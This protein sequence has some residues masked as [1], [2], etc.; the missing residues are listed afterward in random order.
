MYQPFV[1]QL[2]IILCITALTA[3]GGANTRHKVHYTLVEAQKPQPKKILLLPLD[4]KVKELSAGGV[5]EEVEEWTITAKS[6]MQA[7]LASYDTKNEDIEFVRLPELSPDE[8]EILDEHIALYH[9]VV[10]G[11]YN[12]TRFPFEA[13]KHKREKFDYTVGEGLAF[14]MRKTNADAALYIL[15][16]DVISSDGRK[17]AMV[18]AAALGVAIQMGHTV[19]I[20]GVVDLESGD[21]LWFDYAGSGVTDMRNP[22]SSDKMVAD[23]L[24]NYPGIEDYKK[25]LQ[26]ASQ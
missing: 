4:V 16:E 18:F 10:T 13:W 23:L 20:G 25:T 2:F 17:A 11:A 26:A 5:V 21:I 12:T 24:Q 6:N 22:E 3:C 14:L 8:K 15:G 9:H 1:R 7:S 19:L